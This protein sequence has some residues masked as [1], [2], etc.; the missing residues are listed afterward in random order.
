MPFN[1]LENKYVIKQ[2]VSYIEDIFNMIYSIAK[3]KD[4]NKN[5]KITLAL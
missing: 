5:S 4:D 3:A 1:S 2:G